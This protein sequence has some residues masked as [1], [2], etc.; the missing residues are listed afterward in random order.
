R[1][2]RRHD[3]RAR[4]RGAAP[5]RAALRPRQRGALPRAG[6]TARGPGR[7]A[8]D[9]EPRGRRRHARRPRAARGPAR[10]PHRRGVRRAA[11]RPD[12]VN[13]A[14]LA[15]GLGGSRF[16]RALTEAIDPRDVT[17]VG[18]VGDDVEI[19]GLHISPDLD[20][21]T[22]TL[23]GVVDEGRG[24]GRAGETWNARAAAAHLGA[25]TWFQLGDRDLGL[26]LARTEA[27]PR[28]KPLSAGPTRSAR[29]RGADA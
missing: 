16:A 12:A 11:R 21:I 10:P 8:R 1:G 3:E 29:A 18:N 5:V 2:G 17:V 28:G 19:A 14:V 13:V 22:Y 26:H 15:G 7:D 9:P 27:L 24:W 4:A 20:T 25:E 6:R 23:A